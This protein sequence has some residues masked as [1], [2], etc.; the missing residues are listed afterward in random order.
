[1]TLQGGITDGVIPM[2]YGAAATNTAPM[3]VFDADKDDEIDVICYETGAVATTDIMLWAS[4]VP[5]IP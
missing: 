2:P 4:V 5:L 1:M 3:V